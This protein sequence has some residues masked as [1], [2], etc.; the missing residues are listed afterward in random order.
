MKSVR[1]FSMVGCLAVV[2]ALNA[3]VAS[4]QSVRGNFTLP[5]EARWGLATLPAG[6]YSFILRHATADGTLQLYRGTH[7]VALIR[8]RGYDAIKDGTGGSAV[9][10]TREK[11][12][13]SP[14]V[15]ALR[16][17]P[18]GMLFSYATHQPKHGE[19]PREREIAQ[20]IPVV[21]GSK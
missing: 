17:A 5:F 7:S 10:L 20:T 2:A 6:D 11:G 9:I 4:A 8:C 12:G 15:T 16:L 18:A 1:N 13:S 14:A 19:A 3:G 21:T